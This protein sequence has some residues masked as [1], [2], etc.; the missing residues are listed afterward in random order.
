MWR[1]RSQVALEV[2]VGRRE[3]GLRLARRP[4]ERFLDLVLVFDDPEPFA[5]TSGRGLDRDGEPVLGRERL[6]LGG[7]P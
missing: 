7:G 6:D 3:V 5:A 2:D 4:G 1:G